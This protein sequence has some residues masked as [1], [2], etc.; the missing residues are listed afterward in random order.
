MT[1]N[2]KSAFLGLVNPDLEPIRPIVGGPKNRLLNPSCIDFAQTFCGFPDAC[3]THGA[4]HSANRN[5]SMLSWHVVKVIDTE[6]A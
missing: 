1:N 2:Q 6:T 3:R 5:C 4:G